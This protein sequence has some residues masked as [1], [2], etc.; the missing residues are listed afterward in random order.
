MAHH[1]AFGTNV[2]ALDEMSIVGT[3]SATCL[4]A[5]LYNLSAAQCVNR[6]TGL[7]DN[8]LAYRRAVLEAA[9]ARHIDVRESLD[10]FVC[11]DGSEVVAMA[12]AV[13]RTAQHRMVTLVD[14]FIATVAVLVAAHVTSDMLCF[15]VLR[16]VSDERGYRTLLELLDTRPLL[17]L[18]SRLGEGSGA[19]LAYPVVVSVV[20]L[21][22]EV[23]T[24]ASTDVSGRVLP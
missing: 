15:C 11:F 9:I 16:H 2:I 17:S 6:G 8:G 23:A 1:A 18:S 4:V 20:A 10:V 3:A 22:R 7:D 13:P 12:G 14:G 19:V 24:S 5:R 21:L